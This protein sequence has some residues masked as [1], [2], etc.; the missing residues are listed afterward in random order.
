VWYKIYSKLI[1]YKKLFVELFNVV[2]AKITVFLECI[3]FMFNE[4]N[5]IGRIY[6][7]KG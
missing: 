2:N 6:F 7:K 1:D 4:K 3:Y 5:M